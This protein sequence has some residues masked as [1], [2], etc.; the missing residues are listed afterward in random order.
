M[1]LFYEICCFEKHARY[2]FHPEG[3]LQFLLEVLGFLGKF[4]STIVINQKLANEMCG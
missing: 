2:T 4:C 1:P 3:N